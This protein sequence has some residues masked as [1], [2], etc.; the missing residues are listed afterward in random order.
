MRGSNE[1]A[2]VYWEITGEQFLENSG[3][4]TFKLSDYEDFGFDVFIT[5]ELLN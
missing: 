2:T 1:T 4:H 3:K 5:I